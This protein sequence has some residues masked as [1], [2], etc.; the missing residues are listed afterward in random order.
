[1]AARSRG[2]APGA[3]A[4][5]ESG[6]ISVGTSGEY[7]PGTDKSCWP[8]GNSGRPCFGAADG[9]AVACSF[10]EELVRC[11]FGEPALRCNTCTS[12]FE[13]QAPNTVSR[14][15]QPSAARCSCSHA[16][17]MNVSPQFA[18]LSPLLFRSV[19]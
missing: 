15:S 7:S 11:R 9:T 13:P 17:V 10:T 19:A 3:V 4:V 2:L 12:C 5:R 6:E 1:M 16:G 8:A 18:L 14:N